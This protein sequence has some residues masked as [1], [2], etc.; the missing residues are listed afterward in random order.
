LRSSQRLNSALAI[1]ALY[2][3]MIAVGIMFTTET[4]ARLRAWTR[5]SRVL[6]A[7]VIGTLLSAATFDIYHRIFDDYTPAWQWLIVESVVFVVGFAVAS[8]LTKRITL[9][10]LGGAIGILLAMYFAWKINGLEPLLYLGDDPDD[11]G[12]LLFSIFAGVIVGALTFLPEIV[13]AIRQFEEQVQRVAP[14]PQ[15]PE[16]T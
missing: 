16:T 12:G 1:G 7:V 2:G 5:W 6:L 14:R 3:A 4:A 13:N 15:P 9:R 10:S 11:V 8:A